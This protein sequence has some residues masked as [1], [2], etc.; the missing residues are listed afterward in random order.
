MGGI[1]MKF[2]RMVLVN[3][4]RYFKDYRVIALMF[5]LPF[6]CTALVNLLIRDGERGGNIKVAFLNSDR[7]TLAKE[8]IKETGADIYDNRE[9]ALNELKKYNYIAVYEIPE[10]FSDSVSSGLKPEI[11]AHKLE[12]GNN[13]QIFEAKLESKLRE[14]LKVKILQQGGLIENGEELSKNS[15]KLQYNTKPGLL[16]QK[17]FMP[18]VLVM[19]YLC[20]FSSPF[21]MDLLNLRKGKI[22]ERFLST[23]NRGYEIMG[24]IYLSMLIVQGVLYSAS[25]VVMEVAF[26]YNF[27]N[28]GILILNILLMSMV[29]I[30]LIV[31][32][33]RIFKE[34]S[35]ASVVLNLTTMSMFFLYIIGMTGET[36]SKVPAVIV[37]LSK[38]TPFYWSL[39]SIEQ[40]VLFPNVII[41]ILMALVFF[42]AGSIRYSNF[43]K[44]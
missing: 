40:S 11:T 22:L 41:L 1:D 33:S 24:S 28:F 5:I 31:M 29:C 44:E 34:P 12:T 27:Q 30:S 37:T 20:S 15:I 18:I 23:N 42:S 32:L 14:M 7:G 21:I 19:F 36:S 35:V 26:K 10:N 2:L 9:K 16:T 6:V 13:T 43:A 17:D 38:F 4:K 25:F 8:L 3:C 39:G